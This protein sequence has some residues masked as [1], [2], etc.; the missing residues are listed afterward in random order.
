MQAG[1][2]R[3]EPACSHMGTSASV[4][5]VALVIG[6]RLAQCPPM[7]EP[8]LI[9]PP[10]SIARYQ[11]RPV[12]AE[13]QE[14]IDQMWLVRLEPGTLSLVPRDLDRRAL[15]VL[16][17]DGISD[18]SAPGFPASY[19]HQLVVPDGMVD[20]LVHLPYRAAV[21]APIAPESGS[22][23]ACVLMPVR[24]TINIAF[25]IP[26]LVF[27]TR[28]CPGAIREFVPKGVHTLNDRATPLEEVWGASAADFV[29]GT[30]RTLELTE[31]AAI[32]ERHLLA[33]RIDRGESTTIVRR[34]VQA[35]ERSHGGLSLDELEKVSG[36]NE[37]Q[38]ERLFKEHV[39]ISP[40]RLSRILRFDYLMTAIRNPDGCDWHDLIVTLNYCDQPHLIREF[41]DF[42]GMSPASFRKELEGHMERMKRLAEQ[43]GAEGAS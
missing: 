34:T 11:M 2:S 30:A 3:D 17:P 31:L 10:D 15:V 18:T 28:F 42:I 7:A 14:V 12:A 32:M 20:I 26:S 38:L 35:L 5:P 29:R 19:R 4:R 16:G 8:K 9:A 22:T 37:R 6:M 39:G 43:K 24:H 13:L 27:I 33:H 1:S 41:R 36:L 21:D 23:Y 40:K 25:Q